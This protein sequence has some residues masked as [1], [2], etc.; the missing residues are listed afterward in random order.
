MTRLPGA[1]IAVEGSQSV[2]LANV[3]VVKTFD[4]DHDGRPDVLTRGPYESL[5][6]IRGLAGS[7]ERI[8]PAVLL[9]HS[10]KD[11][12]FSFDDAV[13]KKAADDACEQSKLRPTHPNAADWTESDALAIACER[14]HGETAETMRAR[15]T[16]LE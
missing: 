15:H 8:F 1:V 12:T 7:T 6:A 2:T 13:A 4:A 3:H 14:W 10:S 9:G 5:L 11:G 16:N